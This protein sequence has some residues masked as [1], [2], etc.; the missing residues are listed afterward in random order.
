MGELHTCALEG[1][2]DNIRHLLQSH[3][4]EIELVNVLSDIVRKK[5][6]EHLLHTGASAFQ[7]SFSKLGG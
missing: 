6:Q 2:G 3:L 7:R 4:Q 5:G 1:N